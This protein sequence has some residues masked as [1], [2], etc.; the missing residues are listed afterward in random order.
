MPSDSFFSIYQEEI[1]RLADQFNTI[2]FIPHLTFGGLPDE[3]LELTVS[4]IR[5]LLKTRQRPFSMNHKSVDCSASP[6]QNFIH[7]LLP[8]KNIRLLQSDIKS[9]LTK[10]NPK[11]EYHISL[12]YGY[13]SCDKLSEESDY[14]SIKLP[15]TVH[16]NGLRI[17]ELAEQPEFWK[18]VWETNI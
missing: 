2:S 13:I 6:Y 1:K 16:F 3:P 4:K 10:Y 5:D 9:V 11:M 12:M 14:L 17:I 18:T 15:E 8:G 7:S